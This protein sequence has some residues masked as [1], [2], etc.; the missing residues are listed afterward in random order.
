MSYIRNPQ[1]IL[2]KMLKQGFKNY[3]VFDSDKSSLIDESPERD[4]Y[5]PEEAVKDLEETLSTLDGIVYVIIRADNA[6]R[7][8]KADAT[9]TTSNVDNYKGIFK[10]AL[11]LGTAEAE[12]NN[13]GFSGGNMSLIIGLMNDKHKA[14]L[15][16][17]NEKHEMQRSFDE[18]MKTLEEKINKKA[19]G[20]SE[21]ME[22]QITT[23]LSMV[24]KKYNG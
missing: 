21:E 9:A 4:N 2:D 5:T 1:L 20:S 18:R 10:Y 7:K 13:L 22:K 12:K 3:Q 15:Q 8:R 11:K 19:S 16:A 17:M 14:E 24:L 23:L 6:P